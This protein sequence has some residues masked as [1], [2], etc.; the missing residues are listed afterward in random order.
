V[1]ESNE[2]DNL[3][4]ALTPVTVTNSVAANAPPVII[5]SLTSK[6][7]LNDNYYY[8]ININYTELPTT[9]Q[10]LSALP[11]GLSVET[12]AGNPAQALA[13]SG[14]I[15]GI[16]TQAGTYNVQIRASN[17]A[18]ADTKT[19]TI[20]VSSNPDDTV[21]ITSIELSRN[22]VRVGAE[23]Y[24]I[25]GAQA[26]AGQLEPVT[27]LVIGPGRIDAGTFD[28]VFGPEPGPLVNVVF[29]AE[30]EFTVLAAA[31]SDGSTLSF[32]SRTFSV[33][34][35]P[36]SSLKNVTDG[37]TVTNPVD[38]L[39]ITVPAQEEILAKDFKPKSE[40]NTGSMGGV[41]SFDV[42]PTAQSS[43]LLRASDF[44]SV[45]TE[46]IA[47]RSGLKASANSENKTGRSA[48]KFNSAGIF[49]ANTTVVD[50]A[51]K[52]RR[53]RR[54]V[55]VS[56]AE[57][58]QMQSF[59]DTRS[60]TAVQGVKMKGKFTF[61]SNLDTLTLSGT[62]ELP[63]GMAPE[64][65]TEF[66][67]GIG[68]VAGVFA[69][70]SRGKPASAPVNFKGLKLKLPKPDKN[71]GLTKPGARAT[72]SVQMLGS[73][74]DAAG[75]DTEGIVKDGVPEKVKLARPIQVAVV[76]GGLSFYSRVDSA[77]FSVSKGTGSLS[78]I[79]TRRLN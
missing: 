65:F 20:T 47:T 66:E 37:I 34:L 21:K 51:G 53:A 77:T 26:P 35:A 32:A 31:S 30:G 42:A 75:F 7:A 63:S 61:G 67:I 29:N 9:F 68:N 74:L 17:S 73:K 48:A 54:M 13:P 16:P 52:T 18:G 8:F 72:F 50:T 39:S 23:T 33:S 55:P 57:V 44:G 15:S 28:P 38:N 11:P 4:L 78:A 49:L 25:L 45:E 1:D 43:S 62:V 79:P 36:Q 64:D 5:S 70:D 12:L 19:V 14:L 40:T 76:V 2:F 27:A 71:T 22:P 24:V 59:A 58:G 6:T 46:F 41:V 56:K 60:S 3:V 10:A 69:V